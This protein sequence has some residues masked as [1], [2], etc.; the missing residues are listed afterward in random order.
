VT[1]RPDKRV[2]NSFAK[3]IW[4][5]FLEFLKE[6]KQ[7]GVRAHLLS[8]SQ[9]VSAYARQAVLRMITFLYQENARSWREAARKSGRGREIFEALRR[10]MQGPVGL[11]VNQLIREQA[12][13]ISAFPESVATEVARRATAQFLAGGRPM[14]LA[15]GDGLLLQL[16]RSQALLIARTQVSKA[17]VA[18]TRAR[19]EDL[20]INWYIWESSKDQRVRFSHRRMQGV[21]VRFDDPPSPE[22]LIGHKSQGY[23]GAGDIYNCRCY[24]A[25][26]IRVDQVSWP[27]SV[28]Y[29]G[30]V[31]KMILADFRNINRFKEAA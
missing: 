19:S 13:L 11:K 18:L 30:R 6:S 15:R 4:Q 14:E 29:G 25:P 22:M 12:Y 21:L 24:P 7:Y 10:E 20:G 16:A 5:L 1:W 17:S 2:E 8:G 9:F 31:Q 26:L 28:Y 23:Y 27:H 3:D